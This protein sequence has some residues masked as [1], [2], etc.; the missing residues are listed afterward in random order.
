MN[1]DKLIRLNVGGK[2]FSTSRQTLLSF[3]D[4]VLARLALNAECEK[5]GYYFI[6]R[7]GTLFEYILNFMRN[8]N[9]LLPNNDDERRRLASDAKFYGLQDLYEKLTSF[10]KRYVLEVIL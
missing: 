1:D 3:P 2:W 8:K 10:R 9:S 6:D 4:T 5:Q 7:D